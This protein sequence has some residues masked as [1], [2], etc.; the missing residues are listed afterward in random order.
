M[1]FF[2]L[3]EL[4][5]VVQV[6][7]E[8][9]RTLWEPAI[10]QST[11]PSINQSNANILKRKG[12]D[13]ENLQS[14]LC[15]VRGRK[16]LHCSFSKLKSFKFSFPGELTSFPFLTLFA[17]GNNMINRQQLP[18]LG[19]K[20]LDHHEMVGNVSLHFTS[21]YMNKSKI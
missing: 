3:P 5:R 20:Q 10:N 11:H 21:N 12:D 17:Y 15:Y 19:C 14:R 13:S 1:L 7:Q 2:F 4:H 16:P 9:P 18:Y 6:P 8:M